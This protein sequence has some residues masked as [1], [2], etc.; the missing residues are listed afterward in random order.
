M[1]EN[2]KKDWVSAVLVVLL[3]LLI[4]VFVVIMVLLGRFLLQSGDV[5]EDKSAGPGT[6]AQ[7]SEDG[8]ADK[9]LEPATRL[10]P[11]LYQVLSGETAFHK[12]GPSGDYGMDFD[13]LGYENSELVTGGYEESQYT[14]RSFA[15]VDIEQDGVYEAVLRGTSE[16]GGTAY[17]VLREDAA[18]GVVVGNVVG[19]NETFFKASGYYGHESSD[20]EFM[21]WRYSFDRED[22]P[23]A[24]TYGDG[25]CYLGN[26]PVSQEEYEAHLRKIGWDEMEDALFYDYTGENIRRFAP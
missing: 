17:T 23:E 26:M 18:N 8:D 20:G 9:S 7:S 19:E 2:R 6:A 10:S 14:T 4:L 5:S 1:A 13:F 3:I 11:L 22:V 24:S 25:S 16:T 15:V 12:Y 21:L